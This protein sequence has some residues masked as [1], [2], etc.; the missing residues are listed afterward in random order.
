MGIYKLLK[1]EFIK[2]CSKTSIQGMGNVG[3]IEQGLLFQL[4]WLLVVTASI[5]CAGICIKESVDG[6]TYFFV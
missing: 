4:I 3:D 1:N 5:T 2:F 6:K